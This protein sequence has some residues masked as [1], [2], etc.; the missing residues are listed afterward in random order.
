MDYQTARQFLIRQVDLELETG[1]FLAR[2]NQYQAPV[3]GQTTN[4]LLALKVVFEALRHATEL[5]RELT[6][7]LYLLAYDSRQRF[8]QGKK[9]GIQ[10]TPL[11]DEDLKRIAK[12][13]R[14][15]FAGVWR[16]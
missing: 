12:A 9:A 8:E 4:I 3:P 11:L 5:D 6:Y 7:A 2:L 14:S 16:T 15:I 13:V 10:W 1:A